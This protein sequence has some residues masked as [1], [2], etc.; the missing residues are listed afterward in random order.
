[1]CIIS[2]SLYMY[3]C[4]YVCMY[5]YI[6]IY[7]HTCMQDVLH[8]YASDRAFAALKAGGS[9]D[10]SRFVSKQTHVVHIQ[11]T[12][13]NDFT[14]SNHLFPPVTSRATPLPTTPLAKSR[15]S[16]SRRRPRRTT[17][18]FDS[19]ALFSDVF[20]LGFGVDEL[21]RRISHFCRRL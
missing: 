6:Y 12:I 9:W 21:G 18:E 17:H 2:P 7:T 20:D 11:E 1:M 19:W 3:V 4:M 14:C 16:H 8:V 15:L 5:V 10:A 13:N